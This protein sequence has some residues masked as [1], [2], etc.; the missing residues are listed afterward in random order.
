[1]TFI[2]ALTACALSFALGAVMNQRIADEDRR[3]TRINTLTRIH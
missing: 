1:M 2:L 3:A